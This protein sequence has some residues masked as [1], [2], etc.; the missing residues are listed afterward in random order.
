MNKTLAFFILL[1][2]TVILCGRGLEISEETNVIRQITMC[3]YDDFT[4]TSKGLPSTFDSIPSLKEWVDRDKS[5]V[6]FIN[7]LAVVPGSPT[8]RPERGISNSLTNCQLFAISRNNSFDKVLSSEVDDKESGGG[9]P[10]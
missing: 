7:R 4:S 6:S 5:I 1:L 3:V 10:F 9:T 8:I 2:N